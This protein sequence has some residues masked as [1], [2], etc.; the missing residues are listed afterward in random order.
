M[1]GNAA[2]KH[3][4]ISPE[5]P[6]RAK[7]LMAAGFVHV[8]GLPTINQHDLAVYLCRTAEVAV[9][10]RYKIVEDGVEPNYPEEHVIQASKCSLGH[11]DYNNGKT[12][13]VTGDGEVW[14]AVGG[15][16]GSDVRCKYALVQGAFVPCSN[17]EEVPMHL[18]LERVANPYSDCHGSRSPIP[19]IR[20]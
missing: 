9:L 20:D 13:I 14:L 3:V 2:G 10:K 16:R 5:R 6:E 17:G 15:A 8:T 7:E 19:Q 1:T 18:L 4:T 11:C 12:V